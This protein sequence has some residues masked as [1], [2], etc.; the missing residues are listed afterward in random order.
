LEYIR[1]NHERARAGLIAL[2]RKAS[3]IPP[4]DFV[5]DEARYPDW[6]KWAYRYAAALGVGKQ[7]ERYVRHANLEAMRA[8]RFGFFVDFFTGENVKEGHPYRLADIYAQVYGPTPDASGELARLNGALRGLAAKKDIEAIAQ[9]AGYRVRFEKQ[10]TDKGKGRQSLVMLFERVPQTTPAEVREAIERRKQEL[11]AEVG[12]LPA[13]PLPPNGHAP[14]PEVH[15]PPPAPEKA[16]IPLPVS[17]SEVKKAVQKAAPPP[18]PVPGAAEGAPAE[19]GDGVPM[20]SPPPEKPV[21]IAVQSAPPLEPSLPTPEENER[22]IAGVREEL[23][24]LPKPVGL[25]RQRGTPIEGWGHAAAP[26]ELTEYLR[27]MAGALAAEAALAAEK[28][29]G[30]EAGWLWASAGEY[31]V[32]LTAFEP[33][34]EAIAAV[35]LARAADRALVAAQSATQMGETAALLAKAAEA[36]FLGKAAP[37][38][39]LGVLLEAPYPTEYDPCLAPHYRAAAGYLVAAHWVLTGGDLKRL[40]EWVWPGRWERADAEALLYF[41]LESEKKSVACAHLYLGDL[42]F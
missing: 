20:A 15:T 29:R 10:T 19:V 16:P 31:L 11:R 17:L 6:A 23:A 4:P 40:T 28:G 26:P 12:A 7:F 35:F 38:V 39:L 14:T 21:A 25:L 9:V 33:T 22:A 3:K 37:S 36:V 24:R 13:E 41:S 18:E 30:G 2:F 8:S 34:R 42:P 32:H 27:A 1:E 5:L